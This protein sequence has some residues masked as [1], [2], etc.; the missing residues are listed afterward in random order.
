MGM[1]AGPV[2]YNTP[3]RQL[4]T[5]MRFDSIGLFN[6]FQNTHKNL[7]IYKVSPFDIEKIQSK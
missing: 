6:A 4:R 5:A 1:Y 2:T 3:Q 7:F